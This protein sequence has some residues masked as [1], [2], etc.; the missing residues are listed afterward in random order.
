L[1]LAESQSPSVVQGQPIPLG[2]VT[3][4]SVA[5][6]PAVGAEIDKINGKLTAAASPTLWI[7]RRRETVTFGIP[8]GS[9]FNSASEQHY[10]HRKPVS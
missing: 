6:C 5:A 9:F 8:N 10:L 7:K 3:Q 2:F 4:G 1:Q